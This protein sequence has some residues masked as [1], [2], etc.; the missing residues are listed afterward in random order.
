MTPVTRTLLTVDESPASL[1]VTRALHAAGHRVHLAV[2]QDDTY[3]ARSAA[4][5]TVDRLPSHADDR[6]AY[7]AAAAALARRLAIDV[8]LPGTEGTLRA[9]TGAEGAF[10][11]STVVGTS[12]PEALEAATSKAVFQR[13][14]AE[15]GLPVIPGVE[16]AAADLDVLANEVSFP[17]VA[18]PVRSVDLT[19]E[20]RMVKGDARVVATLGELR[21]V[22]AAEPERRWMVQPRVEGTLEAVG[23]VAWRGRL[24]CATH[25]VSPRIWPVG[26]GI[27][28]FALTVPPDRDRE[29][30]VAALLARIGWSGIFGIQFLRRESE[31]YAI[32]FNPRVYGSI[33]LAIAA[34]HNLPAIW[35]ALLLGQTPA[36]GPYR[37]GA[38][39]RVEED[40]VR[41]LAW[42]LRHGDRRHA[43]SGLVPRRG[44]AH[45]VLS[46]RDL[47][48]TSLVVSKGWHV[49]G[50]ALRGRLNRAPPLR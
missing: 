7:A 21:E 37:V 32:D 6:N 44:T 10:P 38:R 29:R 14:A 36:V 25:Q 35:S 48:P 26:T 34:G 16:F 24:V 31:A 33:G 45:A 3:A 11:L 2:T 22:T 15:C 43:L 30:K 4:A 1:A 47:R 27:T 49:A 18:K 12:P 20:G 9:L 19:P 28:A 46:R 17:A 42:A 50:R 41:A 13:L 23:G 8:V 40:D 5:A 39:Y